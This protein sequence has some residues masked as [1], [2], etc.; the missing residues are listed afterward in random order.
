ITIFS[1]Q[2]PFRLFFDG[3]FA[4]FAVGRAVRNAVETLRKA[5]WKIPYTFRPAASAK[6]NTLVQRV[7]IQFYNRMRHVSVAG[8]LPN[9]HI[10]Y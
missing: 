10:I 3:F 8:Y 6:R 1:F 7:D 5:S 2:F 4:R 9:C